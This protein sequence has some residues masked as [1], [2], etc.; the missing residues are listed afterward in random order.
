MALLITEGKIWNEKN[1][2]N[3][4]DEWFINVSFI[5]FA[6]STA[7][8]VSIL[9]EAL[10]HIA[11]CAKEANHNEASQ[12]DPCSG[13]QFTSECINTHQRNSSNS[14]KKCFSIFLTVSFLDL[15]AT[16]G[17]EN[18][19]KKN[20]ISA[21]SYKWY[22]F[23]CAAGLS[24]G[25]VR[26]YIAV[27]LAAAPKF[28]RKIT[29]FYDLIDFTLGGLRGAR[30]KGKTKEEKS[31]LRA[32]WKVSTF[33]YANKLIKSLIEMCFECWK[34]RFLARGHGKVEKTFPNHFR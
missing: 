22:F 15:R 19:E 20:G 12:P 29:I 28:R 21:I 10:L 13:P 1:G 8:V 4:A 17:G 2:I 32:S 33:F 7:V 26:K 3:G 30:L 5:H 34:N 31:K 6:R 27:L 9:G 23:V 18:D 14:R 25:K 24:S 11:P 16:R